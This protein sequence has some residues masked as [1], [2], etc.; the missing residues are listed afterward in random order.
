MSNP[1]VGSDVAYDGVKGNNDHHHAARAKGAYKSKET[2]G[3]QKVEVP[4]KGSYVERKNSGTEVPTPP[5]LHL[6]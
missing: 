5:E 1:K 2:P 6:P 4:P 3:W